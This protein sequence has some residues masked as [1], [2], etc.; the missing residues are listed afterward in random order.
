MKL[1][2][3]LDLNRRDLIIKTAVMITSCSLLLKK[4]DSKESTKLSKSMISGSRLKEYNNLEWISIAERLKPTL[5]ES[6]VQAVQLVNGVSDKNNILQYKMVSDETRSLKS[7]SETPV[8]AGDFFIVE[9]PHH[10]TGFLTFN[11][12]WVGRGNDAPT[13]LRLIF[14][15]VPSD[16]LEPL[17]PYNGTLSAS[18]LPDEIINIDHLPD[19][20]TISRRHAYKYVKIEVMSGSKN[21]GIIFSNI[22]TI[23]VSS[24]GEDKQT[25]ILGLSEKWKKI[26]KIS[27]RTLHECMQTTFED[28]PRRDQRLWLGDLRLQALTNYLSF[29][30]NNLVK[31]CLYLFAGLTNSDGFVTACVYEKPTPTAGEGVMLDYAALFGPTLADYYFATNDRQTLEHLLPVALKQITLITERYVNNDGVVQIPDRPFTFID[32]QDGLDKQASMQGLMIYCCRRVKSLTELVGDNSSS[33]K[34]DSLIQHMTNAATRYLWKSDSKLFVSGPN[35]QISWASQIWMVLA[36]IVDNQTGKDLLQRVMKMPKAITPLTP[37][38][39]HH[40]VSAFVTI[41]D[42]QGAQDVVLGYWGIMA[43]YGVDTFWEAFDPHNPKASPYGAMQ[44]NSYCHAWSCTP[45]YFIRSLFT[46]P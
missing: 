27:L 3:G 38:L 23:A 6:T 43:E 37:Y 4:A 12:D 9:F 18:W 10:V 2:R 30:N 44:I 16:V 28:G 26:E 1:L 45:A 42:K 46:R 31:R 24:A 29:K 39:Y 21:F 13:R 8:N 22:H 20:V 33:A 34:L 40:L 11:M 7:I 19:E 15:E 35:S 5:I 36:G 25:N 14:G 32:W 17:Y 41:G